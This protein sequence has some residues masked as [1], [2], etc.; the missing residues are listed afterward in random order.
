MHIKDH[1]IFQNWSRKEKNINFQ[2]KLNQSLAIS[3][4][5]N[6]PQAKGPRSP[7]ATSPILNGAT[8]RVS[9][10]LGIWCLWPLPSWR[11]VQ[12]TLICT[13]LQ[14]WFAEQAYPSRVLFHINLLHFLATEVPASKLAAD[15]AQNCTTVVISPG[16]AC[17]PQTCEV[18]CYRIFRRHGTCINTGCACLF[19]HP[20][21]SNEG[22]SYQI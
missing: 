21:K 14:H 22:R 1:H 3:L 4:Y 5:M 6:Y 18:D 7:C 15:Q 12:V 16:T 9:W 11:W 10:G 20:G 17:D 19:C 8:N 13:Q 2:S